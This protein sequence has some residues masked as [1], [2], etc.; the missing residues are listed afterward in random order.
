MATY[1][2]DLNVFDLDAVPHLIMSEHPLERLR[3]HSLKLFLTTA[4]LG[5]ICSNSFGY[6]I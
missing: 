2:D 5:P 3:K 1:L 6:T 4:R